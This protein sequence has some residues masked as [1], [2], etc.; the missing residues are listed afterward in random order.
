ML[1]IFCILI[2]ISAVKVSLYPT[3]FSFFYVLSIFQF[4]FISYNINIKSTMSIIITFT[5]LPYTTQS[6]FLYFISS[7]HNHYSLFSILYSISHSIFHARYSHHTQSFSFPLITKI[8][9]ISSR[10]PLLIFVIVRT[11]VCVPGPS[12]SSSASNNLNFILK[13]INYSIFYFISRNNT[14]CLI[15]IIKIIGTQS[16]TQFRTRTM[17]QYYVFAFVP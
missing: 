17:M 8:I 16:H 4:H 5:A 11:Y 2:I 3:F 10:L 6:C 9:I 7:H 13:K 15:I 1:C 14:E 12:P